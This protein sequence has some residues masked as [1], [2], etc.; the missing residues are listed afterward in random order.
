M[1]PVRLIFA[2]L[3]LIL[4]SGC[5]STNNPTED[6]SN[7]AECASLAKT[8]SELIAKAN[9]EL[10]QGNRDVAKMTALTAAYL[11]TENTQCFS[12]EDI[13]YMKAFV[14]TIQ[15]LN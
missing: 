8:R 14:S 7:K 10:K 3:C 5:T 1:K 11:T 2:T 9:D 4:L 13:A 15:N 6:Q 12:A